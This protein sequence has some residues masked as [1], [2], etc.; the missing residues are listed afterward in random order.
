MADYRR[1]RTEQH[2]QV[3]MVWFD[4]P[5]RHFFD[6][7]M[8]IELDD[9]TRR[10][11]RD[12]TTRAVVFTGSGDHY[13]TH[14]DVPELLHGAQRTPFPVPYAAAKLVVADAMLGRV[15]S[16]DRKLRRTPAR[17]VLVMM[18]TYAALRRMNRMDKVVV[19]AI[20]GLALGMGCIFALACDIRLMAGHQQIGL[21]E[22]GLGLL[23]AAGGT[24][25]LVRLVGP[26]RALDLLLDGRWL[27]ATEA[28]DLGLIHRA[29]PAPELLPETMAIAQRL[30]TRSPQI[31]REIKRMVYDAGSRPFAT[32][33]R[34]EAASLL[35]TMTSAHT[36]QRLRAYRDWLAAPDSIT[37]E[38]VRQ[39]FSALLDG[40]LPPTPQE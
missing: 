33:A 21:P 30:A 7:Q 1:F 34:M 3:L 35:T 17:G 22:S 16:V 11:R 8:S 15:R 40:S 26:G 14:F 6:E 18:R 19:T 36:E 24:Q 37:D 27:G 13:L 10:L 39:G 38:V 20:N 23:A 4:N 5:P 12:R 28:A 25:R 29:V 32:A 31:T 9:L 2:G